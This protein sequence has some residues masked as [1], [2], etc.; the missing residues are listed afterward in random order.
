M[1]V[2]VSGEVDPGWEPVARAF[3]EN[4]SKRG[5][6]GAAI[7]VIERGQVVVD[8]WGG[9]ASPGVPWRRDTST[10]VFSATKG[11]VALCLLMLADRGKLYYDAKL[12]AYWPEMAANFPDVTVRM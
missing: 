10:L 4:F 8:L 6:V 11:L 3:R 2:T 1:D 5:E 9:E 12:S 7:C